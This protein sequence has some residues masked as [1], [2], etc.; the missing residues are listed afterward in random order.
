MQFIAGYP[1]DEVIDEVRRLKEKSVATATTAPRAI[2]EVAAGLIT[3]TFAGSLP[4]EDAMQSP[5]T[6][7]HDDAS[8]PGVAEACS[9]TPNS[10]GS[11][12]NPGLSGS[13]SEGGRH[14]WST[15]ARI[16]AQVADGLAYAHSQ[17]ILH[18]DIKPANL[19]LDLHGT[20]WI[21]DFGLAKAADA[22]D[23]TH[24][25]DVVGT[26]RYMAPE[27]FDGAGDHRADVYA[28]GLTL[29][30]LLTL[31][32][33]H[34]A[35]N[36][37]KLVQEVTTAAP[38]APRAINPLI[39]RDLETIV[40]KAIAR[41]PAMRYQSSSDLAED[42]RR[43]MED[44]PIRARRASSTEQAWR[45]CRRNPTVATLLASV[46]VVF[47]AGAT[48]S[49]YF[50]LEAAQKARDAR[51]ETSRA[52]GERDRANDEA[53]KVR[54]EQNL[55]RHLLYIS[56]M[57]HASVA[58]AEGRIDRVLEILA[59][60]TPKPGEADLRGWEWHYLDRLFGSEA[61]VLHLDRPREPS[62]NRKGVYPRLSSDGRVLVEVRKDGAGFRFDVWDVTTGR[63]LNR[64]PTGAPVLAP[65][66]WYLQDTFSVDGK[67]LT[68]W[69]FDGT[70]PER[71]S[72]RLRIWDVNTGQELS[73]PDSVSET[74]FVSPSGMRLGGP[75]PEAGGVRW[76]EPT[77][78]PP[79]L[80]LGMPLS[81][82]TDGK[83]KPVPAPDSIA[84][85]WDRAS[86]R[87]TSHRFRPGNG[88]I[89]LQPAP[90]GLG[91]SADGRI[92]VFAQPDRQ[93]PGDSGTRGPVECWDIAAEPPRRL[94]SV[95]GSR[96]VR[97]SPGGKMVAIGD[98][99]GVTVY[100]AEGRDGEP[101][102]EWKADRLPAEAADSYYF[103]AVADDGRL[104]FSRSHGVA[105]LA[106]TRTM[107]G[108]SGPTAATR[109]TLLYH[110][111]GTDGT[112]VW[113]A[114]DGNTVVRTDGAGD[115]WTWQTARQTE[116]AI[117]LRPD[118]PRGSD[119]PRGPT[120]PGMI[121]RRLGHSPDGLL[122]VFMLVSGRSR[123]SES[124]EVIV[125]DAATGEPRHRIALPEGATYPEAEFLVG[126]QRLLVQ[127]RTSV[128]PGSRPSVLMN[129]TSRLSWE[130][131]DTG[132]WQRLAHGERAGPMKTGRAG[133]FTDVLRPVPGG[134][135]L[136]E[137]GAEARELVVREALTGRVT[138][139]LHVPEGTL[140]GDVQFSPSAD[141]IA[142][143]TVPAQVATDRT[144]TSPLNQ[145]SPASGP[146][147][148]V[149]LDTESGDTLWKHTGVDQFMATERNVVRFNPLFQLLFDSN[150]RL[151]VQY[152]SAPGEYRVWVGKAAD[153]KYER[154]L[155][156][157]A[158]TARSAVQRSGPQE[159]RRMTLDRD[160]RRIAVV[161][162][163]EVRVWELESGA[164]V[165]TLRGHATFI[166]AVE[167]TPDGSRLFAV[168]GREPSDGPYEVHLGVWD[169]A[170]GRSVL[171]IRPPPPV[172]GGQRG[173]RL[174]D[175]APVEFHE[176]ILTVP[177]SGFK[178]ALD[179]NP[180][181]P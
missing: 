38:V 92:V 95:I 86:G 164:P 59:E 168:Y 3:G 154:T 170:T 106:P 179:G 138:C 140:I 155:V 12:S 47:A 17:G 44:R 23:L 57:N 157:P 136:V 85:H 54:A 25:G 81:R 7:T 119:P 124:G 114:P 176:G 52:D 126:A 29:Y 172:V 50:A 110:P 149:M 101:V 163:R 77:T 150:G 123:F 158:P 100:R 55:T 66:Q 133:P 127:S 130:L 68:A 46:L 111:F 122:S 69:A 180:V 146:F 13:I 159:V 181:K 31:R 48:G 33:A 132:N 30:E 131:Y 40:L 90:A 105:V 5:V 89:V 112:V 135:W 169:L 11:S 139:A 115:V 147:D 58:L 91:R 161:G 74:M 96:Q 27:R 116:P 143:T 76:V 162:D 56:Q 32:P 121:W 37:A 113:F 156:V 62:D 153:G 53:N 97:V 15:V 22:D 120:A 177:S 83:L 43:Y 88:E 141:R 102:V 166:T 80:G 35:E 175:G 98:S 152:R 24:A 16:G 9:A 117:G 10:E 137:G 171:A 93:E 87:V 1:L 21:T 103:S 118:G 4:A 72:G 28:L 174:N 78:V 49:A 41:D 8:R 67:Q 61:R 71:S 51:D 99:D 65:N 70:D 167:L 63:F 165:A 84:R 125:T 75:V 45:W 34:S 173:F 151:L 144:S 129:Q 2:S 178:Y 104:A 94:W 73:A 145:R 108:P 160:G 109:R 20:V 36:R 6:M 107:G 148:L 134:R 82:T 60:T 26:L 19:L 14:Y 142:V 79:V 39:P 64:F 18:R 42:L 128:T